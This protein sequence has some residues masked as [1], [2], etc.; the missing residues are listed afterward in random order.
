MCSG[1]WLGAFIW[2]ITEVVQKYPWRWLWGKELKG[3]FDLS[4]L[5]VILTF[6]I[7]IA[8]CLEKMQLKM[9]K[10]LSWANSLW[11]WAKFLAE[12]TVS[13]YVLITHLCFQTFISL[14]YGCLLTQFR[15]EQSY[16]YMMRFLGIAWGNSPS[17]ADLCLQDAIKSV[18]NKQ[19]K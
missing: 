4:V 13:F 17:K 3:A 15:A 14:Q 12:A 7:I 18:I 5:V 16:F 1:N 19:D 9:G 8:Y 6:P 11:K 2:Q 10:I